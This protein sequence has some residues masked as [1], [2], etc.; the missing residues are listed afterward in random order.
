MRGWR[1]IFGGNAACKARQTL[2]GNGSTGCQGRF[3]RPRSTKTLLLQE[4]L[5]MSVSATTPVDTKNGSRFWQVIQ[6]LLR[7]PRSAFG[8]IVI[9][10]M[11]LA[12]LLAP[13][14]V[15]HDPFEQS[16]DGL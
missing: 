9:V 3:V 5:P 12:A 15:P 7:R 16:F 2:T 4:V 11:V 14:I 8:L 6:Q 1:D 10:V 13:W